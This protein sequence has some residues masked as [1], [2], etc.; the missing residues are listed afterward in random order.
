MDWIE[1]HWLKGL[2]DFSFYLSQSLA[3]KMC[4]KHFCMCY[5]TPSYPLWF[6]CCLKCWI[7]PKDW[8]TLHSFLPCF[9]SVPS[10]NW[11]LL[12]KWLNFLFSIF[13]E[14]LKPDLLISNLNRTNSS[15]GDLNRVSYNDLCFPKISNYGSMKKK[16]HN[17]G[18]ECRLNDSTKINGWRCKKIPTKIDAKALLSQKP[19]N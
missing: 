16:K 5:S 14:S 15:S 8:V 9:F 12:Q 1:L 7:L 6:F 2:R 10:S 13:Q 11:V 3:A 17:V 4:H 18:V 19:T